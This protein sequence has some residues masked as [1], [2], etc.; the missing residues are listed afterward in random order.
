MAATCASMYSARARARAARHRARRGRRPLRI[1]EALVLEVDVAMP[2]GAHAQ[3]SFLMTKYD[4]R[5][6][7][8]SFDFCRANLNEESS[9]GTSIPSDSLNPTARFPPSSSA[10]I[11]L[12]DS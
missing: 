3:Y 10:Y 12:I 6:V 7:P 11:T 8:A 4:P 5:I 1:T 2:G 9:S